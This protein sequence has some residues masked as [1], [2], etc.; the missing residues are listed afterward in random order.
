LKTMHDTP[1]D[2]MELRQRA[3]KKLAAEPENN[4]LLSQTTPEK[5][6]DLIRQLVEDNFRHSLDESPLGVRIVT[7]DGETIY[8]NRALLDIYGYDSVDELQKTPVK[9][10][11]TPESFADFQVRRAK[12]VQG[13]YTPIEY[14]ISILRKDGEV[15]RLKVFRKEALWNGEKQFQTIYDDVTERRLMEKALAQSEERYRLI[16]EG[17]TDYFYTCHVQDGKVMED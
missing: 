4:E 13:V 2:E 11:Y 8:A 16:T 5:M 1:I 12:R 7:I 3:E 9:M 15:R 17:L 6:K 14:E 10:R